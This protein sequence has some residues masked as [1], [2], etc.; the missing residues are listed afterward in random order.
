MIF[1][2][3]TIAEQDIEWSPMGLGMISIPL[4][5]VGIFVFGFPDLVVKLWGFYIYRRMKPNYEFED[6][7]EYKEPKRLTIIILKIIGALFVVFGV[8]L[9]WNAETFYNTWIK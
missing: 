6:N 1:K 7:V 4:V 5:L 8:Y 3:K 2:S 9:F